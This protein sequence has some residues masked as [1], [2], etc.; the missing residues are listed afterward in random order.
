MTHSHLRYALTFVKD[1]HLRL[2]S[3]ITLSTGFLVK[4][5][6]VQVGT[7]VHV[8]DLTS[9]DDIVLLSNSY[10]EMQWA[11]S[12]SQICDLF[13]SAVA[14]LGKFNCPRKIAAVLLH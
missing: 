10:R 13:C 8:S 14:K 12:T 5:C 3:E 2:P 9:A 1:V 7:N 4:P 6:E 11:G